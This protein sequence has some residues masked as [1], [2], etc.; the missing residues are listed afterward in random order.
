MKEVLTMSPKADTI[1]FPNPMV[2]SPEASG[3]LGLLT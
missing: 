1:A 3:R 2:N